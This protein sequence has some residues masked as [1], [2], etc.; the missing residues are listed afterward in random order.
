VLVVRAGRGQL[1]GADAR[2]M[3]ERG[4]QVELV[5]LHDVGHDLHLDSPEAWRAAVSRFRHALGAG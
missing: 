5:D 1:S 4:Q 3:V 2:A